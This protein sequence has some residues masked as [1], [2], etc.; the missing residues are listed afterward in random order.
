VYLGPFSFR[1]VL[2]GFGGCFCGV[3]LP[4]SLWGAVGGCSLFSPCFWLVWGLGFFFLGFLLR[5]L[6]GWWRFGYYGGVFVCGWVLIYF[7][8]VYLFLF[9]RVFFFWF[10]GGLGGS[11]FLVGCGWGG[12]FLCRVYFFFLSLGRVVVCGFGGVSPSLFSW[13]F[14]GLCGGFLWFFFCGCVFFVVGVGVL[15]F[16][17]FFFFSPFFV[18][19]GVFF[20]FFPFFFF[21]FCC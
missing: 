13:S 9:S 20:L 5:G 17:S 1:C 18:F 16:F 15:L 4:P 3:S 11:G 6:R 14:L 7:R 2:V 8:G 12:G 21:F 10:L 19:L